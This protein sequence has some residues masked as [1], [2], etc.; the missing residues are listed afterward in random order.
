MNISLSPEEIKALQVRHKKERDGRV[1]DRI[2]AVVLFAQGWSQVQIAQALMIRPETVHDHLE[3]FL[4]NKKLK[5]ENGG[6][7]SLLDACQTQAIIQHLEEHSYTKVSDICAYVRDVYGVQFTVSGMTKWLHHQEFSYKMPKGVPSKADAVKQAEFIAEYEDL[8]KTLSE[9]EPIEFADGVHPTMAT[10]ISY[11]WI[12]KGKSKPIETTASRTRMNLFGS[13]SLQTMQVTIDSYDTLNSQVL[14]EHFKK[15]RV[16][17]PNASKIHLILD[18]G[19]YNTSK[20]T[21]KFAEQYGITLHHLPAYSPNLNPIERL[22]KVMNEYVRNN[23][24]F[25]SAKDFREEIMNFFENTWTEIQSS[26]NTRIN[27]N[28]QTLKQASSS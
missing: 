18:R 27:D 28:F 21:A 26:M 5:P 20:E 8:R 19:S 14:E 16:K 9:N 2:K 4:K 23:R 25:K 7:Q 17:Y 10:K 22:W 3:D 15:L 1:R 11:G 6:S 24:Y 13:I 12:R